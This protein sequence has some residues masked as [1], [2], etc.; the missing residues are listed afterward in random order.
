MRAILLVIPGA[1]Q[2][3][4]LIRPDI[5]YAVNRVC[6][7]MHAPTTVHM[8]ALK[9]ILRY[10]SGTIEFGLVFRPSDRLSLV[11][12]KATSVPAQLLLQ[13]ILFFIPSLN[14]WNSICFFVREKV[15]N[16]SL[17][18]GEVPACDQVADVLTKPLS[19]SAFVRFR[20]C[21]QILPLEKLGEC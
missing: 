9:C 7:F 1:L 12:Q 17:V 20:N 6:Q 16:D 13:R 15:A 10:L 8:V 18:V 5:A 3:I 2:Y 4:V 14:M 11:F 21:L 19:V